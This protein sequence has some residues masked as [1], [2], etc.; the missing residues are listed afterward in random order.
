MFSEFDNNHQFYNAR[1][2]TSQRSLAR[3]NNGRDWLQ[4]H[5]TTTVGNGKPEIPRQWSGSFWDSAYG[6]MNALYPEQKD[7]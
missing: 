4:P 5:S 6:C 2:P 3:Y 1:P 7:I